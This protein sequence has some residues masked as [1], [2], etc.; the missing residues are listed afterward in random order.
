MEITLKEK[1]L[2]AQD[3]W[4]FIFSKPEGLVFQAG[5]FLQ[6]LVPHD[7]PDDRG[8]KRYFTIAASPSEDF[9]MIT[10]KIIKSSSTFK[11]ALYD[12]EIGTSFEAVDP[13]GPFVLPEETVPC[14]LIAGGIGVTPYRSM[15]K[16]CADKKL[17]I[18]L[19]LVYA[20]KTPEE[21]A[22]FD[23]FKNLEKENKFFQAFYTM[24]EPENSKIK[25]ES[26]VG[27]I[28]KAL[29]KEVAGKLDKNLY[30]IS[31][32][33][34]MVESYKTLLNQMGISGERIRLDYFPGYENERV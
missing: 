3:I 11:K 8:I 20:N 5:Q 12:S 30:Y 26:R 9:L 31:G 34:P 17:P 2:E 32:P 10:T 13:A 25:W 33:E 19:K 15:A 24:T 1:K 6:L 28:D 29:I 18:P 7:N 23:F 22:Y 14:V 27:R 21:T 16:F 4:S